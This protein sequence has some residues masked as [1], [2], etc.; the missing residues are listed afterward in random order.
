LLALAITALYLVM[1]TRTTLWDRDEPRFARA[2]VEM[3]QSGNYLYPN[4]NDKLRPDKPIMIYWLMSLPVRLFGPTEFACRFFAAIGTGLSCLLTFAIARRLLS[5]SAGLWAMVILA[6]TVMVLSIGTLATADAVLLPFIIGAM[7]VFVRSI[8]R[9][10]MSHWEMFLLALALGGGMLTKG[11]MG[12]FPVPVILVCL[13]FGRKIKLGTWR[14]LLQTATA[15]V[16]AG[17][18][19]AAWALPAN[20]ATNG[21]FLRLFIGH[22]VIERGTSPLE[23]HGGNFLLYLPF[24]IPVVIIGFFPW[25][26]HL[27]GAISAVIAGRVGGRY[28]RV[29]LLSWMITIFVMMTFAATKLAHYILFIWPALAIAAGG[30]LIAARQGILDERDRLWLRRGVWFFAPLV[31]IGAAGFIGSY[32]F[33]KAPG[34]LTPAIL[35]AVVLAAMGAFA[36]KYQLSGRPQAASVVLL[37]GMIVFHIPYLFG[38]IPAIEKIK[39]SPTIAS[40]VKAQTAPD[41]PVATYKY[42]EPTLNF[43]IG[44]HIIALRSDE[45]VVNWVR[46]NRRGVLIITEKALKRIESKYGKLPLKQ[47]VSKKGFNYSKGKRQTV[48]AMVLKPD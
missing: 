9:P 7:A 35:S 29:L 10:R 23:H 6:S 25:T 36:V 42:A 26:M 32:W 24:Y 12:V 8:A 44:R 1:I 34:L 3:V 20:R 45:Q 15:T 40:A 18:I 41:V 30:T 22:H 39:I 47:L 14:H 31:V 11:P 4:F 43:Y 27:P 2:T 38:V 17:L 37:V 48:F 13:W 19:F 5:A 28:G 33:L 46:G 16:I 21:E